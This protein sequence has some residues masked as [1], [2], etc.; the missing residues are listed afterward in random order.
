[1]L[2]IETALRLVIAKSPNNVHGAVRA[3][4]TAQH[5][6][7]ARPVQ[8]VLEQAL[9]DPLADFTPGERASIAALLSGA[10]VTRADVLR[11]R[12]TADEKADVQHAADEAGVTV[13]EYIRSRLGLAD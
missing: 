12:V 5:R 11:L 1:M 7:N 6:P 9:V 13:S 10:D 3:L 2:D 8:Y 4:R